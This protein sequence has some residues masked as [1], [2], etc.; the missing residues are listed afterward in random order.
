MPETTMRTPEEQANFDLLSELE[1][2]VEVRVAQLGCESLSEPERTLWL[3]WW[4]EA[5]VNNGGFH[6]YFF[7]D[8]GDHAQDAPD[9]LR[10]IGAPR[11]ADIVGKALA[12]FSPSPPSK[13]RDD[14]QTQLDALSEEKQDVLNALDGEFYKYPDPLEVLLAEYVRQRRDEFVGLH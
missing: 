11:C 9:A 2:R 1:A 7:N 4:L 3:V 8:A 6:Q 13:N 12:V 10:R 5:E 14:R